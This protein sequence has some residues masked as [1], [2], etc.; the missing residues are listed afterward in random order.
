[1]ELAAGVVVANSHGRRN[2]DGILLVADVLDELHAGVNVVGEV[3]VSDTGRGEVDGGDDSVGKLNGQVETVEEGESS[4]ERVASDDDAV[5]S[6]AGHGLL[7]GG[8][9]GSSGLG[10]LIAESGVYEDTEWCA[11][12]EC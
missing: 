12:E 3:A 9:N 2:G 4:A 1:M 10:L 5:G 6:E 11:G 8:K 7:D